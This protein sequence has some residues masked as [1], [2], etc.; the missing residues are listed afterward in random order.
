MLKFWF[1]L[2]LLSSSAF[3]QT[4]GGLKIMETDRYVKI[5]NM[6]WV[7]NFNDGSQVMKE[8]SLLLSA[9]IEGVATPSDA[10]RLSWLLEA[11]IGPTYYVGTDFATKDNAISLTPR[12]KL[13]GYAGLH[14]EVLQHAT[15]YEGNCASLGFIAGIGDMLFAKTAGPEIWNELHARFG[16][17]G[18]ARVEDA[19][20]FANVGVVFP[21]LVADLGLHTVSA[22]YTDGV[23]LPRGRPSIFC[24]IGVVTKGDRKVS[25][26]F[27]SMKLSES[28]A[29]RSYEIGGNGRLNFHQPDTW[30]WTAS[31]RFS[32][33]F[34]RK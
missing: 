18:S 26:G 25:L 1:A 7:E 22:G 8:R 19:K 32:Y 6:Y 31:L 27:D 34:G 3:A 17:E 29:V 30:S 4:M 24:E 15:L 21:L 5:S 16:I 10:L 23:Y 11:T 13:A 2:F 33:R 14:C 12:R 28:P 9:G 20:V